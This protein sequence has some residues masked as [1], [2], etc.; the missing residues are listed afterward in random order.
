MLYLDLPT[1]A[2]LKTLAATRA[3]ACVSI[4]LPTTPNPLEAKA[5][6]L[7]L[8]GLVKSVGA[9]LDAS[10]IATARAET[11]VAALDALDEDYDLWRFQAHGLAVLGTPEQLRTYRLPNRL[12]PMAQVSDRFHLTP[13]LRAVT[14]PHEAFVLALSEGGARL[15]EV[16][17]D[18]PP[19]VVEV[20][21]VPAGLAATMRG[22]PPDRPSSSRLQGAEGDKIQ[23]R[24]YARLVDGALRV[25]L[26]GRDTPLVIAATEPLASIY[27]ATCSYSNLLPGVIEGSPDRVSDAELARAVR[28]ILDRHYAAQLDEIRHTFEVRSGQGRTTT[29]LAIAARAATFGA[30]ETLLVDMD[31]DVPGVIDH[32]DGTIFPVAEGAHSYGLIDEVAARAL[33]TGARVLAVRAAD[34]LAGA[35]LMAIL[36]HTAL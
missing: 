31:S 28:P 3:D 16:F 22:G 6:R 15:I 9:Q 23:L 14:F 13:L 26:G 1:Q 4:Y 36:R 33:T 20:P 24:R 25:V 10:A 27:R 35:Q 7:E 12:Q 17:A 2:E 11:L 34:L 30:I 32:L 19:A 21:D 5:M 18:L 8:A 29:D